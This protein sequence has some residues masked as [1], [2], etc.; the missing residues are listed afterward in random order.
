MLLQRRMGTSQVPSEQEISAYEASHP[1]MFAGREKWTL[2]QIVYPLPKDP[3]LTA[4]LAAA[5]SLDEIAQV[6]TA[7]GIQFTRATKNLDTA[8]FP[9][10]IYQQIARLPAGEPFIAPGPDKAVA[11]VITAR[12]PAPTPADQ[13]RPAAVNLMR[14]EQSEKVIQERVKSLRAGAKI[15]YQPGFGP[16]AK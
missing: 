13:A 6:L 1:Q 12:E 8:L 16:G 3:T 15:Q 11:S 9:N 5:K 2:S 4:K 7:S 10:A 14:R